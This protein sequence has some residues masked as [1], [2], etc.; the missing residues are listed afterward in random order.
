MQSGYYICVAPSL[1]I[2]G[3]SKTQG[4]LETSV[5]YGERLVLKAQ[6]LGAEKNTF[7]WV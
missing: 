5:Y 3:F 1:I 4:L 7:Q 6:Q 2:F